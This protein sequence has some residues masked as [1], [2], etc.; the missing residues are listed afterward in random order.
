MNSKRLN[1][2]SLLLFPKVKSLLTGSRIISSLLTFFGTSVQLP[3]LW[4]RSSFKINKLLRLN[5][6]V[7]WKW[8]HSF[9][10]EAR[11]ST[12]Q[13]QSV[14]ETNLIPLEKCWVNA[15]S[16]WIASITWPISKCASD[17]NF[18]SRNLSH[19]ACDSE[20]SD[21]VLFTFL[22]EMSLVCFFLSLQMKI[23]NLFRLMRSAVTSTSR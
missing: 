16:N 11:Q 6:N 8:K 19:R 17:C 9:V 1:H 14:C 4:N 5:S 23:H 3:T 10:L 18:C 21:S 22:A 7:E 12:E 2:I 20:C 13:K 15:R